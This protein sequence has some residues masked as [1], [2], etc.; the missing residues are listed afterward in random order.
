MTK[1]IQIAKSVVLVTTLTL[2]NIWLVDWIP[3]DKLPISQFWQVLVL[4]IFMSSISIAAMTTWFPGSIQRLRVRWESKKFFVG[5]GIIA[6]L[7]GPSLSPSQFLGFGL[8]QI[9]Q[10]FIFALFIGVDEELFSRGIVF[11]ALEEYGIYFAAVISS[12]HFGLLHLTNLFW[13]GQSISYTLGQVLNAGTF[14]FL[15]VGIM[16]YTKTIW[17]GVV[18][19]GLYDT[20]MQFE[21]SDNFTKLITGGSNWN[22]LIA[23]SL[24]YLIGGSLLLALNDQPRILK[25]MERLGLTKELNE[26]VGV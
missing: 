1:T 4:R 5:L 3:F 2:V 12:I 15:C 22:P 11:A 26:E 19:H 25:V 7:I 14:G 24:I 16:I 6:F 21:N 8:P 20:P 17:F 13:G 23:Q 9:V 10:G 18:L